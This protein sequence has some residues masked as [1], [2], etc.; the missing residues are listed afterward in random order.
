MDRG[1]YTGYG[2]LFSP[3]C[4]RADLGLLSPAHCHRGYGS[5]PREQYTLR[6]LT[7]AARG[8]NAWQ[9]GASCKPPS[10]R[11]AQPRLQQGWA[12]QLLHQCLHPQLTDN[13]RGELPRLCHA[14]RAALNSHQPCHPYVVVRTSSC[15]D[16]PTATRVS[17][18]PAVPCTHLRGTLIGS[19]HHS[20]QTRTAVPPAHHPITDGPSRLGLCSFNNS[21]RR[22]GV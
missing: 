1:G 12:L 19:F 17:E 22:R 5:T 16:L 8:N 14:G 9:A 6:L 11:A 3:M 13:Q 21:Y 7:H 10:Q 2:C 20:T 15:A 4:R 18:G